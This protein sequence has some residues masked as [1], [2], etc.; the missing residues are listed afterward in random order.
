MDAKPKYWFGSEPTGCD[1]CKNKFKELFYD[2][3]SPL[4]WGMFCHPCFKALGG[5]TGRRLGQQYV[6]QE[7]GRWLKTKG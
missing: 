3:N 5:Q 7:D 6:K 2:A 1:R 4:G